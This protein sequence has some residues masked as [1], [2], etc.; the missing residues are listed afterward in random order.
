MPYRKYG[1]YRRSRSL[2]RGRRMFKAGYR[3]TYGVRSKSL[4]RYRKGNKLVTTR[5]LKQVV[6]R[7]ELKRHEIINRPTFSTTDTFTKLTGDFGGAFNI[8]QGDTYF[9]RE[10]NEI[11][12]KMV[13][14]KVELFIDAALVSVVELTGGTAGYANTFS[15]LRND[16]EVRFVCVDD[17]IDN[18]TGAGISGF[19]KGLGASQQSNAPGGASD[20]WI[21]IDRNTLK[22][23]GRT[24]HFDRKCV[25]AKGQALSSNPIAPATL[26]GPCGLPRQVPESKMF[27][28]T[29][30][31]PGR[32][33]RITYMDGVA[34][35]HSRPVM[36]YCGKNAAAGN[37]P[38]MRVV[39]TRVWYIDY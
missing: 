27:T 20:Y 8:P 23:S 2:S 1:K 31:Y 21:D 3:K 19:P 6:P 9:A 34:L 14:M 37:N 26:L 28:L 10:G 15:A 5:M 36:W 25:L 35:P 17:T 22:A 16:Q 39:Y 29:I 32:G 11:Y 30:K 38:A 7:P 12:V 13:Q 18:V 4:R 33:K 24:L